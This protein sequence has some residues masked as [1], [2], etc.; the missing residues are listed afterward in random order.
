MTKSGR[1]VV[2]PTSMHLATDAA[3]VAVTAGSDTPLTM[4]PGLADPSPANFESASRPEIEARPE[5]M[6]IAPTSAF[7]HLPASGAD[8]SHGDIGL[9]HRGRG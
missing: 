9:A 6:R 5:K 7:R 3:P 4:N 8:D 2:L 1:A